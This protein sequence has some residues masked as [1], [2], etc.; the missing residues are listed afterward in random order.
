MATPEELRHRLEE[1]QV[2][3]SAEGL[4]ARLRQELESLEEALMLSK[5]E[6]PDLDYDDISDE[7]VDF[8]IFAF[9]G[10]Y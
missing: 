1:A 8:S 5:Q 7:I 2:I 4:S 6:N 10:C 9:G 3:L